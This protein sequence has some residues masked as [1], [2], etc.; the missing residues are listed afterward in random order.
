MLLPF[1]FSILTLEEAKLLI[2]FIEKSTATKTHNR[3][4]DKIC[5]MG[6][7]DMYNKLRDFVEEATHYDGQLKYFDEDKHG[8]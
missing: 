2:S 5:K 8:T 1:Q 4:Y 6:I 7:L 3:N